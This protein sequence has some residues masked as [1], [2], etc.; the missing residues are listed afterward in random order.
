LALKIRP[1]T[2]HDTDAVLIMAE[3]MHA[4][5]PRF[6]NKN[7]LPEKTINIVAHLAS[8]GGGFVAELDGEL[9][10]MI[11]GVLVPHFFSDFKY[12]C[13]LVVFVKPDH[14]GSTVAI[15][16]VKTFEKWAFENGAEEVVLGVST[17]VSQERTVCVYQHLGYTLASYS[18]V[19]SKV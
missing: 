2:T 18:L 15:R 16:L 13:D 12:A 4:E 19:K 8:N 7:F 1:V 14:R 9:V 3:A 6:R 11:G 17:G 10:G 5:S